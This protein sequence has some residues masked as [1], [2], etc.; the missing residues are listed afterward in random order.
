[1]KKIILTILFLIFP[2]SYSWAATITAQ[3]DRN[4]VSLDETFNLFFEADDSPDDDPDFSPLENDFE[5]IS[6]SQ[7][8]N[9]S[10]INGQYT[11][12]IK[13]TLVVMARR[14][15][16]LTIPAIK[17]GDD[18]SSSIRLSVKAAS[19]KK[20]GN[21]AD[22]F[23][24]LEIQPEKPRVQ[25]QVIVTLRFLSALN[26]SALPR[27]SE[28]KTEGV[29]AIVEKLGE[30]KQFQRRIG[31]RQYLIF[32]HRFAIFPQKSG[33]LKIPPLIAEARL[34]GRSSTIFDPFQRS[35]QIKR[36]RS[37]GKEIQVLNTASSYTGKHWLPS[38][39][40]QL[41]EEWPE[42]VAT[43]KAGEPI[44]RTLT[45]M[46]DGLTS[47]QL[48]EFKVSQIDGI[49]QYPDKPTLHD[50]K[51]ESGIIGIRQEKIAYI[52][53]RPGSYTLPAIKINWWN[54]QTGKQETARIAA[55]TIKVL[56]G[57]P[58]MVTP[59]TPNAVDTLPEKNQAITFVQSSKSGIW[60]PLSLFLAGGWFI[61]LVIWWWRRQNNQSQPVNQ[62]QTEAVMSASKAQQ[63]LRQ[64][65]QSG[66]PEIC[67]DAL[68][69]WGKAAFPELKPASLG[70]LAALLNE[71]L[72]SRFNDLEA[73]LYGS[74]AAPW[75]AGDLY[76]L[77]CDWHKSQQTK[78]SNKV[79]SLEPMQ[80]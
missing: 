15:G 5:I 45:I 3:V 40:I 22:I 52:P 80:K 25:S 75:Q 7:G 34:S 68:L 24:E 66:Q 50:D 54:T 12:K 26:L 63:K 2:I 41:S 16:I 30:V 53:S 74:Q 55:K 59:I 77:I 21:G 9:I 43:Y 47:A 39:E 71:P 1:M 48:P 29:D 38:R 4:P 57:E 42:D 6:Q 69:E 73:S 27:F 33:I 36:V 76:Q 35:G 60:F 8:S 14:V 17:F 28:F 64:A 49:K 67:K 78:A 70:Q 19:Q 32:E 44:T 23:M 51:K 46:A 58:G 20:A 10:I 79:N 13:W 65:C 72:K 11:K 62:R 31:K 56:S 61:T 18:S 37:S